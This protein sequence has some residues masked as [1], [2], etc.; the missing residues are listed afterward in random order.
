MQV[1][2]ARLHREQAD[3]DYSKDSVG[4]SEHHNILHLTRAT[5]NKP[6]VNNVLTAA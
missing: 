1:Q 2:S 3:N 4:E 5:P 6:N